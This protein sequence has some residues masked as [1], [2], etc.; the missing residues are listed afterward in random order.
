MVVAGNPHPVADHAIAIAHMALDMI[1]AITSYATKHGTDLTIRIGVHTGPVVAGV[2]GEKKFIYDLWGDTVNTAS[3]MESH[4][5]PGRIHVTAATHELLEG[6]FDF[7]DRGE[8]EIKG[9]GVMH[10][11]L[12]LAAK[13][14]RPRLDSQP[15]M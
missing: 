5:V 13:G 11:W 4:G 10:T 8:H 14:P 12:L 7:E 6:T 15:T 1:D 9:K 3:R 2:I